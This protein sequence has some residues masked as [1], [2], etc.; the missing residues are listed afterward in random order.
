MIRKLYV[1]ADLVDST[2]QRRAC[3]RRVVRYYLEKIKHL[4]LIHLYRKT[5]TPR[6]QISF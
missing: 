4:E 1:H 3:H 5:L 6:R 2:S